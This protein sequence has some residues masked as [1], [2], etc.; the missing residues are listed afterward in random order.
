MLHGRSSSDYCE[1]RIELSELRFWGLSTVS[2]YTLLVIRHLLNTL[3][4][5]DNKATLG[6]FNNLVRD[7]Q[8]LLGLT[9]R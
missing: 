7:N 8:L 3:L 2:E 9:E 5:Q 6:A 4:P 1:R